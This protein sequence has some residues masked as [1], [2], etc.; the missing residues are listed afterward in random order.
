MLRDRLRSNVCICRNE[1]SLI[2]SVLVGACVLLLWGLGMPQDGDG[3]PIY[4]PQTS[5]AINLWGV[6]RDDS[7]NIAIQRDGS[8][9]FQQ[10][11]IGP[12][13][14]PE[15]LRERVLR[16]SPK[17]VYIRADARSRYRATIEVLDGIHSAGL[18]QVAFIAR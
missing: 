14:L 9:F 16:G 5:N 7:L 18:S 15:M 12:E 17:K 1:F 2:F 3:A 8:I 13:E 6:L 11:K 10:Y 4:L